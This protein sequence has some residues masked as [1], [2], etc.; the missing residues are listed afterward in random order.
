MAAGGLEVAAVHS[1]ALPP[2]QGLRERA[3]RKDGSPCGPHPSLHWD[4]AQPTSEMSLQGS[5]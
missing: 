4:L 5:A 1:A 2:S 3:G